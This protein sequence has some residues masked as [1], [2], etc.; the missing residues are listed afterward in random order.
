MSYFYLDESIHDKGDFIIVACVY[1]NENLSE[2][3]RE[4][5]K[6]KGVNPDE[7]E[8]KSNTNYTKE[9]EKVEF[10][11]ELKSIMSQKAKL[12]IVMLPRNKREELGVE[13]IKALKQFIDCNKRIKSP[14]EI[15]ID[16]SL[17]ASDV[18]V[19]KKINELEF[20]DCSF[21]LQVD[22]KTN[23]GI[24]IADLC[25]HSCS[26]QLK[27]QM[28]LITKKV[29]FGGN[30]G[31]EEDDVE[32]GFELWTDLRYSYF[33]RGFK[34]IIDDPIEDSTFAVEPYGLF[35]SEYCDEKLSETTR[36]LFSTVYL[37]C[38]H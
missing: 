9:P 2:I 25:A 32:L 22:S 5:Y 33:N 26:I 15:Y 29:K 17:V 28:G 21:H 8:F 36:N 10:R 1:S 14:I 16:Q 37:G 30:S 31:Y 23:G 27:E 7:F 24:Q 11:D 19:T 38:I 35:V 20:V 12:G 4:M 6:S 34:A 13:S 18:D 3:V